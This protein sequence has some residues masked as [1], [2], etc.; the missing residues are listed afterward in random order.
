MLRGCSAKCDSISTQKERSNENTFPHP[1]LVPLRVRS[2]RPICAR[3]RLGRRLERPAAGP[4]RRR[5]CSS[6]F[7]PER[8][9]RTRTRRSSIARGK[10]LVVCRRLQRLPHALA[11]SIRSWECPPPTGRGCS[12]GH[13][14]GGPDPQGEI[15]PADIGLI[16]PTFTS[17]KL[18]FGIT[19]S[20]NLTPD[21]DTGTGSW[22]EKMFLDVFRKGR[23]L[24]GDGRPV[25]PPMPWDSYRNRSDEDLKA[26][27]AYLQVHPAAAQPAAHR[28]GPA[29][30]GRRHHRDEQ[31]DHR[32]AEEPEREARGPEERAAAAAP[33]RPQ[34]GRPRQ[35]A[36][37]DLF[38][39]AWSE[40]ARSS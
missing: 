1:G 26:M 9:L 20:M 15:G 14:E 11:T 13:P 23:H 18:P 10:L 17:F 22:T 16:G 40:R 34:A 38:G 6:R 39:R 33:A 29:P 28:E 2:A 12:P 35:G 21:I 32:P 4:A 36:E 25:Y 3:H 19:Y 24:G 31:Q 8:R 27:F 5:R 37:T 7:A 30:G